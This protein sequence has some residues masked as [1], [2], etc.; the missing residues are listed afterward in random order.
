MSNERIKV[1]GYSQNIVYDNKI[2][3]RNFSP[4]LV[5]LQLTSAGGTPLFTMG[6]FAIT[7]NFDPK[8][9]KNFATSSFSNFVSL[10]DL[11]LTYQS[12]LEL[13]TNNAGVLLNLDKRNLSNYALFGSFKEFARVALENIIT[14]WPA[15]LYMNPTY[16]FAPLYV[17]QSGYTVENYYFNVFENKSNFKISTNVINN[18]FQINYLKNGSLAA[19]FNA[20]NDLRDLITNYASYSVMINSKEYDLIGFT[21]ATTIN[22]DYIYLSVSGN[23]FSNVIDNGY[24]IYYIKPNKINENLFYNTLPDF[25]YYLL[26]RLVYPKFTANFDFTIKSDSGALVYT[27][28]NI[29][30]PTTDG[31]NID[32]DTEEYSDY[33]TTLLDISSN[34]D[35]TTSNLIV[36][37]LVTESITDFDT[38][39]IHFDPLD[40]DT[41]GQKMN[42]TL[43]IYGAEFDKLNTFV[44]GIKFANTVT[45]NKYDN[46][47]D[48]YLKNISRILGWDVISSVLENN[49]LKS[50]LEPKPSTYSGQTVGLT[51]VEA[52]IELWRRIILN[53]PWI[54]KSKGTRKA[55]EFMF[56]FIGT[57][58]GLIT[59]N[60]YVYLA[61]NKIDIDVFQ[62]ALVLNG[63]NNDISQY[64]I[65][66]SGYPAPLYNTPEMYFQNNGLWYRETGGSNASLD[67][68]SGN[69]PHAGPYDGGYKYINQFKELIP[70][71][72]A[73]T[74]T[75]ETS[76]TS[77]SN[78]FTNYKSG[79][80]T[81]YTGNT[82]IDI[83]TENGVDFAN[84]YVVD[85]SITQDPKKRK[86]ETDCG[87]NSNETKLKS[88]SIC[89]SKNEGVT[90]NCSKDIANTSIID[91]NGF[92]TY[93]FYQ[94]N[95]DGTIYPTSGSPVYYTS[96]FVD[97]QCCSSSNK[98]P[99]YYDKFV[100][101]GGTEEPFTAVNSG[102]ICCNSAKNTCGCLVTCKW[103]L[104]PQKWIYLPNDTSKYIV[105]ISPDGITRLTSQDG[106]NCIGDGYST[107]IYISASTTDFGYACRLTNKGINDI[108]TDN[109][110]INK[111]YMSRTQEKIPCNSIY[112]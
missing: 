39:D 7:T 81:S 101:T 18:K 77:T 35:L 17:T 63:R 15:A 56:K 31:Y 6:N 53:T 20:S 21:G 94:Y 36:R 97:K 95:F 54:W 64:P 37:F 38:T 42:K 88:L 72:S 46:T 16:S 8:I 82:Y 67:I 14:N 9:N 70:N 19:T 24:P 27:N 93:N 106:C 12:A 104:S 83:S 30:W 90:H 28:K 13:L 80:M 87:C 102:Y 84:C 34:F 65:S 92:Y 105:F 58:L 49:L 107:P 10:T 112:V 51:A 5:G 47:P 66:L 62:K 1:A 110:I 75:S 22:D 111:T 99:Y 86:D 43:T 11:D 74:I 26:N 68:T 33:A 3:R 98:T 41:S 60:E 2:E 23:V 71:F 100:G 25:E 61:E 55:I 44:T 4:D 50:Y 85:T 32:F 48:I 79:T 59:F 109:S 103:L 57:P 96:E 40:E 108:D 91:K 52:D 89:I 29:T 78:L 69:N 73:V 76:T 45:Y